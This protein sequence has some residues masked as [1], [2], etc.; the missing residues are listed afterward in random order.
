MGAQ[1]H[2]SLQLINY[3]YAI[4]SVHVFDRR[5]LPACMDDK[6]K[7]GIIIRNIFRRTAQLT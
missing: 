3:D 6:L 5:R 2:Q 7:G 4:Q 1:R